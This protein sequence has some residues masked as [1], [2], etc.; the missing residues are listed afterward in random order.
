M[1]SK[2]PPFSC[3]S[4]SEPKIT[5]KGEDPILLAAN[6]KHEIERLIE[7]GVLAEEPYKSATA[8]GWHD[9]TFIA[10]KKDGRVRLIVD[11]RRAY[12]E[13]KRREQRQTNN[14][15]A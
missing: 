7:L 4:S 12:A 6:I 15:D 3:S 10:P 11:V 13:A 14:A 1:A 8:N 2:M 5:V 9:T